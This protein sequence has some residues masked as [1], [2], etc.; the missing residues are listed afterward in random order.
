M[1]S[2]R[3]RLVGL[4]GHPIRHSLSPQMHNAGFAAEDLDYVYVALEVEPKDL[5]SA[6][7]GAKALGFRGFNVT[8]PTSRR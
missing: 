2:G 6:V 4:I 8:M 7:R 5:P 3:T 1:I